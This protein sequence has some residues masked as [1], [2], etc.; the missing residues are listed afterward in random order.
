M[1]KKEK[2]D[3]NCSKVWSVRELLA[4]KKSFSYALGTWQSKAIVP[5][6]LRPGL[7]MGSHL[8]VVFQK[9]LCHLLLQN[10]LCCCRSPLHCKTDA[11]CSPCELISARPTSL[12]CGSVKRFC[13]SSFH[14]SSQ[15]CT[16]FLQ[17]PLMLLQN[18]GTFQ[19]EHDASSLK[20]G[21]ANSQPFSFLFL[22]R[23]SL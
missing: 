7:R 18:K 14:F 2:V 21:T 10:W 9:L 22:F 23:F 8:L 6:T 13:K 11:F 1:V 3:I 16:Q 12:S 19:N 5:R 15:N 4:L 20:R 17:V